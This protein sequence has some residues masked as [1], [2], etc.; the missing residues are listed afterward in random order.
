MISC[1]QHDY[2]ELVCTYHY[3]IKLSLKSGVIV[4]GVAA[5][6]CIDDKRIE[7]IKLLNQGAEILV[8]LDSILELSVCV[9]NPYLK[10]ISFA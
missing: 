10:F 3:P 5:D 7:C 9:D 2:I 1:E 8:S 4:E 6:I